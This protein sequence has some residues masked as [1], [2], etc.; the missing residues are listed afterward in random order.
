MLALMSTSVARLLHWYGRRS[1]HH[2][3]KEALTGIRSAG[4]P[5]NIRWLAQS[6][7]KLSPSDTMGGNT[8][9]ISGSSTDQPQA[10]ADDMAEYVEAVVGK[11]SEFGD[12][13]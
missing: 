11:A 10:A 4:R 9:A 13:E 7:P 3:I 2:S 5:T 6:S 12:N 1:C 8:S